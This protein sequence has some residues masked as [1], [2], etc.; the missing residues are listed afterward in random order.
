MVK[1]LDTY[2]AEKAILNEFWAVSNS[3]NKHTEAIRSGMNNTFLGFM[4]CLQCHRYATFNRSFLDSLIA[5]AP[6]I[7]CGIA[8]FD[9]KRGHLKHDLEWL[10][11]SFLDGFR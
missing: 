8:E 6:P 9:S 10:S 5:A 3:R 11:D 2:E 4:V 1:V 7:G